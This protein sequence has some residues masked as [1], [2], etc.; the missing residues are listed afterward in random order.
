MLERPAIIT[1][2][3]EPWEDEFLDLK[4]RKAEATAPEWPDELKRLLGELTEEVNEA[5][6]RKTEAELAEADSKEGSSAEGAL[7][8]R[9][10]REKYAKAA[11][12]A[13]ELYGADEIEQRA[14]ALRG[15]GLASSQ[16]VASVTREVPRTTKNDEIGITRTLDRKY[17]DRLV[18]VLREKGTGKWT[19]PRGTFDG[20]AKLVDNARRVTRDAFGDD[21]NAWFIGSAPMAVH[22]R[23]YDPAV[24]KDKGSLGEKVFLFRADI[25]D[26]RIA[27]GDEYDDFQWLTRLEIQKLGLFDDEAFSRVAFDALGWTEQEYLHLSGHAA[28]SPEKIKEELARAA[29]AAAADSPEGE[30][31]PASRAV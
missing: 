13:A 21:L 7:K 27:L 17:A 6:R 20:A 10:Q 22:L 4:R 12:A 30:R 14:A 19:F 26:G 2:D 5:K 18:L 24:Q 3:K 25:L 15:E 28:T 31:E 23:E 29:A 9:G 1:P 11:A 16:F 8:R